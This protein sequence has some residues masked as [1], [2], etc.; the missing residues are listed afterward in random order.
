MNAKIAPEIQREQYSSDKFS[1]HEYRIQ[2]ADF[3]QSVQLTFFNLLS[4]L[5]PVDQLLVLVEI[6]L[7][8]IFEKSLPLTDQ[9]Q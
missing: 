1:E 5:E 3:R 4:N 7:T 6:V 2:L 8:Q 9:L